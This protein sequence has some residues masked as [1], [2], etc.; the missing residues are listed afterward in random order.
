MASILFG[1]VVTD[2]RG[3][4][5]G[6]VFTKGR[7]GNTLRTKGIPTNPQTAAQQAVRASLGA[8][9]SAWRALTEAQRNTWNAAVASFTKTNVFGNSYSPSGK[10]LYVSLNQN[11]TN[12]QQAT[13]TAAPEPAAVGAASISALDIA[14][15]TST[16]D[17]TWANAITGQTVLV[18]LTPPMSAGKFFVKSEYR[19]LTTAVQSSASPLDLWVA[20]VAR[21]GAPLAGQKVYAKV[22]PIKNT[23]GQAGVTETISDIASA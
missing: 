1:L 19:L 5:G 22:I 18:F 8:L 3:K 21:F 16:M 13:I 17:L 9:S 23:T 20:Y 2:A 11:L 7:S 14:V 4:L 10:N 6:H 12:A 15:G